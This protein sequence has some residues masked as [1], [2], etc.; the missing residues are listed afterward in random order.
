MW[1]SS[2]D[3][4]NPTVSL[5]SCLL[6]SSCC[7]LFE[8][9]RL[10]AYCCKRVAV[11]TPAILSY[12]ELL[13]SFLK[14]LSL[15]QASLLT[16]SIQVW[17]LERSG[18]G[19]ASQKHKN[20]SSGLTSSL[21]SFWPLSEHGCL[22][23]SFI[24]HALAYGSLSSFSMSQYMTPGS[25]FPWILTHCPVP[26]TNSCHICRVIC[27]EV[28]FKYTFQECSLT[29][30]QPYRSTIFWPFNS[31][32]SYEDSRASGARSASIFIWKETIQH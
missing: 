9:C 18:K 8:I 1:C 7:I 3:A 11:P 13:Y 28:P 12:F 22:L 6:C 17:F 2:N 16:L 32:I 19:P 20:V 29:R 23:H 27:T 10:Q 5:I 25:H 4:V 21:S 24:Y 31:A 15:F 26:F 30:E 14:W